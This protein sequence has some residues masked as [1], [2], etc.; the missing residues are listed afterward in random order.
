MIWNKLGEF[1]SKLY[2]VSIACPTGSVFLVTEWIDELIVGV[3]S[4]SYIFWDLDACT[5]YIIPLLMCD[6]TH[7]YIPISEIELINHLYPPQ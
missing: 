3:F 5:M 6:H 7:L 1:V 4:K 2:R